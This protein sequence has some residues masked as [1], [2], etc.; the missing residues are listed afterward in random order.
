MIPLALTQGSSDVCLSLDSTNLRRAHFAA[1]TPMQDGAA[2]SFALT[3]LALDGSLLREGW[4]VT[5]GAAAPRSRAN[6]EWNPTAGQIEEVVLRVTG[7]E[8]A[9]R[10]TSLSVSLMDPLD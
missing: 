10:S 5:V 8:A 2:S 4:D 3:L 7:K 9:P 1:G 6:L